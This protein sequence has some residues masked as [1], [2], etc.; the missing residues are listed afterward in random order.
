MTLWVNEFPRITHE[1]NNSHFC[2][3]LFLLSALAART[4]LHV[5]SCRWWREKERG[6]RERLKS[7]E[8]LA[9][10]LYDRRQDSEESTSESERG[11]ERGLLLAYIYLWSACCICFTV[12]SVCGVCS[13]EW[14]EC[15]RCISYLLPVTSAHD[16]WV[17]SS[18]VTY[19]GGDW[20][21]FSAYYQVNRMVKC[22][23][24]GAFTHP[25]NLTGS[26]W[27]QLYLRSLPLS[28]IYRESWI[29]AS[30][31]RQIHK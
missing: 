5:F 27:S 14:V 11:R 8:Q 25:V 23:L 18:E 10:D 4:L 24:E 1:I 29:N 6:E 15:V 31:N 3:S 7:Q 17:N 16:T 12:H 30:N 26:E 22:S 21:T 28:L 20:F 9:G 2:F 13:E 19:V